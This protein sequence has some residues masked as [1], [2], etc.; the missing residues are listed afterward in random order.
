MKTQAFGTRRLHFGCDDS[1]IIFNL[2]A[3][4]VCNAMVGEMRCVRISKIYCFE[5]VLVVCDCKSRE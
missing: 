5:S 3:F 4:Y 2:P 1:D